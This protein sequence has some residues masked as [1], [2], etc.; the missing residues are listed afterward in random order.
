MFTTGLKDLSNIMNLLHLLKTYKRHTYFYSHSNSIIL[1][2]LCSPL[3]RNIPCVLLSCYS[4][5]ESCSNNSGKTFLPL[6]NGIFY[7]MLED[8]RNRYAKCG[9]DVAAGDSTVL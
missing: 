8:T 9:Q 7:R 4:G 5:K 2:S 3:F 1:V 6:C